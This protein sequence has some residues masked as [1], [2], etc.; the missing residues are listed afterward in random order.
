MNFK[1]KTF[2]TPTCLLIVTVVAGC[3]PNDTTLG[4]A[5][6]HNYAAQVVDPDPQYEE[7]QTLE[8]S[9]AEGAVER[10]RTDRVKKPVGQP[11]TVR[12]RGNSS[13]SPQ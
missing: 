2:V 9:Q 4:G 5:V 7:A 13:G 12:Q 6:R 11:T 3:T 1:I 10:Y 8:G